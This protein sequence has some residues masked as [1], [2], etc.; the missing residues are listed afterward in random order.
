MG[1]ATA[2]HCAR[3]GLKVLGLERYDIPHTMGSS[4]G[5]TRI[6][7]LAY[8]EHPSYVPLLHRAYE[9][10]RELQDAFGRQLLY[11]TGSLDIGP[12]DDWVFS[13]SLESCRE[14]GLRHEVLSALEVN[15]RYPGYNLP[16]HLMCLYQP[17]G[18]FLL[19][20]LC[21]VAHVQ[22]AQALGAE[23]HAREQVLKWEQVSDGVGVSTDRATYKTRSLVL[24]AGAWAGK[25]ASQVA[26]VA[27]PERQVLAWLQPSVPALFSPEQFPVFNMSL[28]GSRYYG[29][30]VFGV[31]GFKLG[32]YRHL[33]ETVDPDSVDREPNSRDEQT[34]REF[35]EAC[36]PAGAGATMALRVC[37]FTNTPDG[38]FILDRDPE[39]SRVWIVSPCSGHGFKFC[40]VIGEV[41]A[42]LAEQGE[43]RHDISLHRLS[44]FHARPG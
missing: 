16:A 19:S 11:I 33:R 24:T 17:D 34:L 4:H 12:E 35:A 40:S 39:H 28:D 3:R 1:S 8:S 22:M 9:L 2:Y 25:L 42:D 32:R 26:S 29:L 44:R 30:P 41:M 36:F 7:R 23:I 13:G 14:H 18:G 6:I 38:H 27:I 20:E 37:M 31:P 43:T 15:G 10:W 21:I 5:I